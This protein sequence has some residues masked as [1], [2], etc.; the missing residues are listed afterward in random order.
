MVNGL[1]CVVNVVNGDRDGEMNGFSACCC[2]YIVISA[3]CCRNKGTKRN[4]LG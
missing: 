2:T 1:G 4:T 3:C